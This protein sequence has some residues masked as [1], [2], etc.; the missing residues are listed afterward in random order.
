VVTG[1]R[2]FLLRQVNEGRVRWLINASEAWLIGDDATECTG[3]FM[4][5]VRSGWARVIPWDMA[6]ATPA[7][8]E[9]EPTRDGEG[10][11]IEAA[12]KARRR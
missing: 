10:V 1:S 8:A 7:T 5:L 12:R 6:E 3:L 2:L 4:E 11:L 9:T